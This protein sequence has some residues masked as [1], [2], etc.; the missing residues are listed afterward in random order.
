MDK[1]YKESRKGYVLSAFFPGVRTELGKKYLLLLYSGENISPVTRRAGGRT[2]GLSA[3]LR[4]GYSIWNVAWEEE[5]HMPAPVQ[6]WSVLKASGGSAGSD[7][8]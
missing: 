7:G 6:L 1:F 2:Q 3:L 5:C 4:L 8:I